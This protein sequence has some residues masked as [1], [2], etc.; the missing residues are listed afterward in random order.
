LETADV[1]DTIIINEIESIENAVL[2]IDTN[3]FNVQLDLLYNNTC[4]T[5]LINHIL[6]SEDNHQ[7][8]RVMKKITFLGLIFLTLTSA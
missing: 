4:A 8:L 1:R 7:T 6:L 5:I 3:D 2:I